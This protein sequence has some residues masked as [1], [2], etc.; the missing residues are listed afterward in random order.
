MVLRAVGLLDVTVGVVG[1]RSCGTEREELVKR[2]ESI[3]TPIVEEQGVELVELQIVGATRRPIVRLYI[4]R[5]GGVTMDECA[6]VSRRL[7]LELDAV[8]L[9]ET[10]YTLEVSSPGLDRPLVSAADFNRR[11]GSEVRVRV[12]GRKKTMDGTILSADG[13]LVLQ[14]ATGRAEIDFNDVEKGLLK[15]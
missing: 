11:R 6:T 2:L 3:V 9:I 5:P 4:D 1:K 12:K 7:S 14:T 15:F 10:S 13:N 8:D